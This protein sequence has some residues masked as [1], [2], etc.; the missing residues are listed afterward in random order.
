MP[1]M[2]ACAKAISQEVTTYAYVLVV[3]I[4]MHSHYWVFKMLSYVATKISNGNLSALKLDV[5]DLIT[6]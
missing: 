5:T 2:S 6:F 4:W 3:L 1:C